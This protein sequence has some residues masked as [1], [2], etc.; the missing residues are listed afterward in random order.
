M[1]LRDA[2]R[3]GVTL[4]QAAS[5]WPAHPS[6]AVGEKG[7]STLREFLSFTSGFEDPP[8]CASIAAGSWARCAPKL[9]SSKLTTPRRYRYGTH[10]MMVALDGLSAADNDAH[11]SASLLKRF[12]DETKLLS[13]T[14]HDS[15][16][17]LS[18]MITPGDYAAF[19][20]ALSTHQL[21]TKGEEAA[22]YADQIGDKEIAISPAQRAEEH[23]RI[24][25]TW[26]YGL[27]NWLQ[28]E[29]GQPCGTHHHSAG[30]RGFYP[31][32]DLG[33]DVDSG[34]YGVVA[35]NAGLGDWDVSHALYLAIKDELPLIT[36]P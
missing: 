30:A 7:K 20:R 21:L 27:G 17:P 33:I 23:G 26:H 11:P 12:Q 1:L 8:P 25:G 5:T 14:K 31:F 4:E 9:T 28:C 18:L 6:W 15:D 29:K 24:T 35:H 19:L 36:R 22:M 2:R 13:S 3:R 10:H 32:I 16:K 34:V